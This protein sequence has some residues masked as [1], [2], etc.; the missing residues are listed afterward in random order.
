MRT[1]GGF[2]PRHAVRASVVP[3]VV[4]GLLA[5]TVALARLLAPLGWQ[6]SG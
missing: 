3:K 5:L 1:S 2:A 6:A 4:L